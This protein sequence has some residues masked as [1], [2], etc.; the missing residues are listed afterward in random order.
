MKKSL[1]AALFVVIAAPTVFGQ[2]APPI[3]TVYTENFDGVLGADSI[4]ANYNTDAANA[5]RSWNDTNYLSTTGTHSFHTQI[6]SNDS[7]IFETDAFSTV[8]NTNVRFTFDQICKIRYI[9]KGFIQ[10]SRDSGTTWVNLT[11]T[12]YQGN[13][14]Q[15]GSQGWF[16]ELAYPSAIQSP[17]WNG[18]TIGNNNTGTTPTSAWWARE[19]FDL[20]SYL[21][22]YDSTLSQDGYDDCMIRFVMSNKSGTPSPAAL[23]GWFVDNLMVEIAPCGLE[24]PTLD[25]V[26]IPSPSKPIGARYMQTQ[27]VRLKASDNFGIDSVR[28]YFRRFD[29]SLGTWGTWTDSLM[30]SSVLTNCPANS[31]YDFTWGNI[32]V[33]DT[34]EWYVR[35]FDCECPNVV[36][37]PIESA[38]QTSYKFW[39]DPSL[40][41]ICGVTTQTSF[42]YSAIPPYDQDFE[43]NLFW[44]AGTGTGSTG[45]SHRGT[46]PIG[47]PPNGQN[48]SVIPSPL[49]I[50]YAWSIRSGNTPT[51]QTG[52]SGDASNNGNGRYLYTEANQGTFN[53]VTHFITPCID[54][55][56]GSCSLLE[57]DYHMYGNHIEFLN[58]SIDTGFNTSSFISVASITG[59]QQINS[60]DNWQSLSVDLSPFVGKYVRIRFSGKKGIQV[61]GDIAVDNIRVYEPTPVDVAL[62]DVFNPQNGYCSYSNNELMDLW[63]Q[64]NGCNTLDSIRVTWSYEYTDLTGAISNS[65]HSEWINY[66][67]VALGDSAAHTFVTGPDLSG[68]GDY[69]IKVYADQPLDS[70]NENDTIGPFRII[71]EEPFTSFPYVEDFDDPA[72]TTPGNNTPI[73]PGTFS[74]DLFEARPASNSGQFAFMVGTGWTPT[75]GSGPLSDHSKQGNYLVT[76]GDYGSAPTS[77]LLISRCLD[78][79]GMTNPVLQFKHHMYGT[80]I[81]AIRVQWIKAGEN[82]WSN[83]MP[84]YITKLTDEKDAWET[85]EVDLSAQ[86]G[87]LIKLRF[88]AQ[89]SGNGIAADIGIDDIVIMDQPT[90]DLGID[91]VVAPG[92]RVNLVA[93]PAGKRASFEVRN[94]GSTTQNS[95]PISYT[96]TPTCGPNAGVSTTYTFTHTSSVAPGASGTA[97]D[98]TNTVAWPTG[99]FEVEAWTGKAGDNNTWNDTAYCKS[100]G[101]PETPIQ[102][103][104]IEDFSTCNNGDSTGFFFSGDLNL[105]EHGTITAL[106]GTNGIGTNPNANV[107][108]NLTEYVFFPRFTD[109]DTIAGAELRI[110]HDIDLNTGDYAVLELLQGGSWN[111]LGYW[112]PQDIVSTG[113]YNTGSSAVGDAWIGNIGQTTS[114][115]PLSFMFGSSAPLI[116]RGKMETVS[117]NKDGWNIGKVEVYIPPQNSAAPVKIET[118]EYLP[119]PDQNNN[120]RTFIRNTGAKV[121][122]SCMVEY[123]TDGGTTWSTPEKVLFDPPLIPR[124]SAPYEFTAPWVNPTSGPYNVC[125]RTSLPDNKPDNLTT[126]DVLCKTITV[127]D[128]IV[129]S[130]DSSYCNNFDDPSVSPWVTLNTFERDGL[131]AWEVGTPSSAP[132]VAANSGANA[133]V[134]NLD[135][136][137]KRRDSS[138]LFTPVFEIDS[139]QVYTYEFMHQFSTELYHDGG[140]VDVTFDG[141]ITWSTIGTNLFGAT[142]FNTNFVTALD[143]YNP[144]WTGVS[145]GWIP[146]S[147]NLSVDTAR[148][149]VFRFRFASD[150]TV[151]ASG[152]AIDDFCFYESDDLNKVFVVGQDEL[153]TMIGVGHLH[154]NPTSGITQLPIAFQQSADVMI[155]VRNTQGQ[156]MT[157]QNVHGEEGITTFPIATEGWAAG[158]YL[159][160]TLTPSGTD[161]QRLIVE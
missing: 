160:E 22:T 103:G 158:M 141:G 48:Y 55:R 68:Y 111:K 125:V 100:Y 74:N 114:V 82:T 155:T 123:S 131:T 159:V 31:N 59:Q 10:M 57:F 154:P 127:L 58:I 117:G 64:N 89:K 26:N 146:A 33:N 129:M 94:Y 17:F 3:D 118:V 153:E 132:I 67:S 108:A 11:G 20:S 18:P 61:N 95:I 145:N 24:P 66:K 44:L 81:G 107:P 151:H 139:G 142:W 92:A 8:G 49:T 126:D 73:N 16:N 46:F 35:V 41:A 79:A 12:H 83:P 78:L 90:V 143:V 124:R 122:D 40:P 148:R 147:I 99:T 34:I 21:G 106:G 37:D 152:W 28:L 110:T 15:F 32:N 138:S 149:A 119:I 54:L 72:T 109:F 62:R 156:I 56:N 104:F 85:Y 47:N 113:W 157:V 133:W 120:L 50:G 60:Q 115:W 77:A 52:P 134:T 128:K 69:L 14:P 135:G 30:T 75:V 137:Y 116:I 80:D 161:V 9:Q 36:R 25:F 27:D 84:P 29:F 5:T 88:I 23:A 4:G 102:N 6:Y 140:T 112:D 150:E 71:H 70:I 87:N 105:F 93:G 13:S 86:A 39:R 136:N 63:V 96:V 53:D 98:I 101:W 7:I 51:T 144:G 65:M 121:L 1:L 38:P 43:D 45:V 91:Y 130:Q 76:E 97:T 42:P 19:T 2:F